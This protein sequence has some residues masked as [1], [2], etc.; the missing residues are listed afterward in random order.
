MAANDANAQ[1]LTITIPGEEP[2]L[3]A[4]QGEGQEEEAGPL[5]TDRMAEQIKTL[6]RLALKTGDASAFQEALFDLTAE[7]PELAAAIAAFT[8]T[9][10]SVQVEANS[11]ET[12]AAAGAAPVIAPVLPAQDLI[13]SL[14]VAATVGP[15]TAAP[16]QY[17]EIIAATAE[18]MPVPPSSEEGTGD[19]AALGVPD[20]AQFAIMEEI[21]AQVE[22]S[23]IELFNDENLSV[24]DLQNLF[25]SAGPAAD[26]AET[27]TTDSASP[28]G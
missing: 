4:G 12:P 16:A 18:V 8:T 25:P 19:A 3:P 5:L 1:N 22:S 28:T 6:I 26:L 23:L 20:D 9:E 10:I 2:N 27:S 13:K 11:A 21:A 15:A 17:Q 7:T 14:T 24:D